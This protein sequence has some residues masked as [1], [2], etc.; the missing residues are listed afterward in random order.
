M[1]DQEHVVGVPLRRL[2]GW[3]AGFAARHGE[4]SA[5]PSVDPAGWTIV[6]TDAARAQ[7]MVPAW[8]A[9]DVDGL[10]LV[11]T[12][13]LGDRYRVRVSDDGSTVG[14]WRLLPTA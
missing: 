12:S 6:A 8:L 13:T 11:L 7:I 2:P 14:L 5:A 4:W 9:S 3:L 1:P 10:R